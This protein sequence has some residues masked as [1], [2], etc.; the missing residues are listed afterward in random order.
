MSSKQF[1]LAAEEYERLV[2]L[3]P[4]NI[5]FKSNLLRAY[6]NSGNFKLGLQKVHSF[7]NDNIYKLPQSLAVEYLSILLFS[8]SLSEVSSY[9]QHNSTLNPKNKSIFKWGS[10]I[11]SNDYKQVQKYL[12]TTNTTNN[13]PNEIINI[14]NSAIDYRF[15]S[16]LLASSL[17]TLI[18]GLG[19]VYT[20]NYTDGIMSLLF[21]A[22]TAWQSYRGFKKNGTSSISGWVFGTLSLG[23]YIGNIYGSSKAAKRYNKLKIN[24]TNKQVYNFI[25]SYNF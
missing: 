5:D 7:N 10:I 16:P 9:L 1:N 20:K 13:L 14:S 24:E 23:F 4:L 3:D 22:G 17:S 21:V 2:F 12:T 8:N 18:P 6:R 11:L 25:Q 15:K 19:K